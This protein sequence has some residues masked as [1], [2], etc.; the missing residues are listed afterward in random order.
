MPSSLLTI[1]ARWC[2]GPGPS[3]R[4]PRGRRRRPVGAVA[5]RRR[6]PAV[7]E[8]PAVRE[9]LY[10][11]AKPTPRGRGRRPALG[12]GARAASD[13][14]PDG[15]AARE[16]LPGRQHGAARTRSAAGARPGRSRA[17]RE[18]V[19]RPLV[20]ETDLRGA[21]PAH[22]AAR[23]VVRVDDGALDPTFGTSYG[24]AANVD[25][26]ASTAV[27]DDVYAPPSSSSRTSAA[28]SRRRASRRTGSRV[29][30]G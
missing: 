5:H 14:L 12:V 26:F 21:E 6:S 1:C 23:R 16:H 22:R 11:T 19:H 8:P 9:F 7:V 20:G 3:P 10:P 17:L 15:C 24:P 13:H 28:T 27:D 30:E 18:A 29:R 25:A 2:R 4:R